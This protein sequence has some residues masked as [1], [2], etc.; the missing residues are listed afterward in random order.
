MLG[1]FPK[2]L[3]LLTPP[4][5]KTAGLLLC[6]VVLT[7]ILETLGI[8]S[9]IPFL[10]VLADPEI[11]QTNTVLNSFYILVGSP[12]IQ[13]FLFIL[14]IAALFIIILTN[15]VSALMSWMMSRF[16]HMRA[17][18]ISLRLLKIYLGQPY[19]I[20][21]N[22]DSSDMAKNVLSE[23][24]QVVK[25]IIV[26]GMQ[27]I[28]RIVACLFILIFLVIVDP[29]LAASVMTILGAAYTLIYLTVRKKIHYI[30]E[31]RMI[32]TAER[33]KA[34]SQIFSGIKDII[35]TRQENAFAQKYCAPSIETS[36]SFAQ[37]EIISQIPRYILETIAF[38]TIILIVLYLMA[39]KG[40]LE[41]AIPVLGLYAFAGQRLMPALQNIFLNISK[42][43][44]AQ[45]SLDHVSNELD[46][47]KSMRPLAQTAPSPL[48]FKKDITVKSLSF[49]YANANVLEDISLTIKKGQRIGFVGGTG[50]G[51]STLLDNLLGLLTPNKGEILIDGDLLGPEKIQSWQANIGYVSQNIVLFNDT[52]LNN[53]ALG[54]SSNQIDKA[55]AIRASKTAQLHNYITK[56]TP[57]DYDTFIGENGVRLSGG[58]RQRLG[59]ARALYSSPEI[60][61]LD[62]ATSALDNITEAQFMEAL[63]NLDQDM[64]II[65]IAHRLTTVKNCDCIYYLEGGKIEASGSYEELIATSDKF[66]KLAQTD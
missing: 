37:Y 32:S 41:Q 51:K 45:A 21:L 42:V 65:M 58:Q 4:E 24:S 52:V 62:E 61:I 63:N 15:G 22:R 33:F 36:E 20:F 8:A 30:G 23:V 47:A 26:P 31:R 16:S 38:G 55:A 49:S 29:I 48:E 2:T 60:L 5:R 34:L 43:R 1:L 54:K 3:K 12:D 13:K 7:A 39:T 14:G 44:F 59:I 19:S 50:A 66:R 18:T 17:H 27:I 6:L 56:D 57:E 11:I 40:S 25:N 53:I 28:A 35:I 46:L 10:A 9:I 64:T